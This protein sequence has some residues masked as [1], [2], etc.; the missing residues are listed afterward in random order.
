MISKNNSKKKHQMILEKILLQKSGSYTPVY[1][2]HEE[3]EII[4]KETKLV[5]IES[6]QNMNE[7]MLSYNIDVSKMPFGKLSKSQIQKGYKILSKIQD[8]IKNKRPT[9]ELDTLSCD[10][11]S[12]IPHKFGRKGPEIISNENAIRKKLEMLQTLHYLEITQTLLN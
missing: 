7:V 5:S 6:K 4:K 1:I 12:M 10:F 2:D 8:A 9:H 11:Y 3:G